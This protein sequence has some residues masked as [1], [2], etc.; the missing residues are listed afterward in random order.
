MTTQ[1]KPRELL[2][3]KVRNLLSDSVLDVIELNPDLTYLELLSILNQIAASWIK[4]AI[5]D[6]RN[7]S[8]YLN[9]TR[10]GDNQ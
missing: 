4:R 7:P 2:L 9:D 10:K 3:Q 1:K 6:E 8:E 5:Q